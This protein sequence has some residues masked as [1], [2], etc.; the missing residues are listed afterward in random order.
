MNKM[1][2]T[3]VLLVLPPLLLADD[4]GLE[5]RISHYSMYE[6]LDRLESVLQAKGIKV[7]ALIDHGAEAQS[8]GLELRP[9]RL[10]IFGSPKI[11]TPLMQEAPTIGLDLPMKVLLWEDDRG[12]VRITWTAGQ[13]LARRHG[14]SEDAARSL[15]G[16]K[17]LVDAALR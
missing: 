15:S 8:A 17:G 4:S 5:G 13:A 10:L 12:A 1:L 7:L 16:V 11:G 9:T 3:L 2:L 14:L 6:T